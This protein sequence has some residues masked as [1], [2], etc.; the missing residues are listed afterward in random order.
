MGITIIRQWIDR[1]VSH[2]RFKVFYDMPL[3]KLLII[4]FLISAETQP[5]YILFLQIKAIRDIVCAALLS[6]VV[7]KMIFLHMTRPRF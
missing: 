2:E 1:F 4:K 7:V 3:I 5:A 6:A